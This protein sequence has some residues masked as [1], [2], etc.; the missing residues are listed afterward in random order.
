MERSAARQ[1]WERDCRE[2]L[3]F[4]LLMRGIAIEWT[5]SRRWREDLVA[6]PQT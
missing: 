3:R 5:Q 6:P 1:R 4:G 2:L